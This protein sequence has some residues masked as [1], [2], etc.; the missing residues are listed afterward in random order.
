MTQPVP[1]PKSPQPASVAATPNEKQQKVKRN[2]AQEKTLMMRNQLWPSLDESKLWNRKEKDGY[3]TIPRT[4]PLLIELINDLSKSV[5]GGKAAPAGRAYLALWCRAWDLVMMANIESELSA[6]LEAGY[7]GERS[8]STWRE[9]IKILQRLGF[10]DFKEGT[11]GP[12]QYVLLFNPYP[13]V[14]A[15]R[16]Q[17]QEKTYNAI[18]QRA[19]DIGAAA[20]LN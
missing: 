5:N 10:I 4:L 2:K 19:M 9:H 8:I 20:D 18:L 6:A 17:L 15:L 7:S 3:A 1:A 14:K 16:P 12:C 13:V 11:S